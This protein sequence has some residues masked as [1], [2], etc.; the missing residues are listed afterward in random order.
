MPEVP[1]IFNKQSTAVSGPG[2]AIWRPKDS[3]ELDYEGELGVVIGKR[4]RRVPKDKAATVIAGYTIVN[5]VSVRDWQ[6]RSATTTMGKSWDTHCPMGPYIV[7]T[8]EVPDPHRLDLKTWVNGEL[9]QNSN[10]KHL[11]FNCFDIVEHLS[12]AFTLEPGDVIATGT[13]SGVI[14]GMDPK[15]WLKPGD[16]VRIAIDQLGVLENPVVAEPASTVQY[17]C[18]RCRQGAALQCAVSQG[19]VPDEPYDANTGRGAHGGAVRLLR[20]H[21]EVW[22]LLRCGAQCC[23]GRLAPDRHCLDGPGPGGLSPLARHHLRSFSRQSVGRRASAGGVWDRD[24]E[25]AGGAGRHHAPPAPGRVQSCSRPPPGC[26]GPDARRYDR[27]NW[28]QEQRHLELHRGAP[29]FIQSRRI[30]VLPCDIGPNHAPN[31]ATLPHT[32]GQLLRSPSGIL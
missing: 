13:P 25:Y 14:L 10:T 7:T 21:G 5:D 28:M 22:A 9:R 29:E 15:I 18:R 32:V 8:D 16:V 11:I 19:T 6:A 23:H 24:G 1:M 17:S 30:E 2:A 20:C 31:G 26:P 3:V 12:T 4:C 27:L